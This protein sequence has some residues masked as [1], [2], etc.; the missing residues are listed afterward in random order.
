MPASMGF[1]PLA[2]VSQQL[3]FAGVLLRLWW[4]GSVYGHFRDGAVNTGVQ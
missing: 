1:R 4:T 2:W 3:W